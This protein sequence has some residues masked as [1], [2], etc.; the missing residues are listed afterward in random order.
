[1]VLRSFAERQTRDLIAVLAQELEDELRAFLAQLAQ[2]PADR[3]ADEELTLVQH[4][5][6]QMREQLEIARLVAQ[7]A[8]LREKRGAADPEVLVAR[9]RRQP[10]QR[11]ARLPD[12]AADHVRRE[13]TDV[14][15]GLRAAHEAEEPRKVA[16]FE[17]VRAARQQRDP[18]RAELVALGRP[19]LVDDPPQ[20]GP[21]EVR[22]LAREIAHRATDL[23]HRRAVETEVALEVRLARRRARDRARLAVATLEETPRGLRRARG[24]PAISSSQRPMAASSMPAA[25]SSAPPTTSTGTRTR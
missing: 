2:H 25:S 1:Q 8:Q 14:R 9:P 19:Q 5:R 10:P 4:A 22:V 13:P 23:R 18:R 11:A 16:L 6:R 17:P 7:L 12:H 15:P 20:V 21:R 24:H 3:L